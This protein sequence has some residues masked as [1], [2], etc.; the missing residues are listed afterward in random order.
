MMETKR[1]Q[2]VNVQTTKDISN[3]LFMGSEFQQTKQFTVL[4]LVDSHSDVIFGRLL[5]FSE[6]KKYAKEKTNT[7]WS[8]LLPE[9]FFL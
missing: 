8:D 1:K 3:F 6:N 2:T 7:F 5:L 9:L 4:Q